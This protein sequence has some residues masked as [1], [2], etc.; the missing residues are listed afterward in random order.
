MHIFSHLRTDCWLHSKTSH[1]SHVSLLRSGPTKRISRSLIANLSP[2]I[3]CC[4]QHV[5][6][7]LD[8]H[9][10]YRVAASQLISGAPGTFLN[11]MLSQKLCLDILSTKPGPW[12]GFYKMTTKTKTIFSFKNNGFQRRLGPSSGAHLVDK[13]L[14]P[15]HPEMIYDIDFK[16][17]M[18][19]KN[20]NAPRPH[21]EG[22]KKH[23]KD[24]VLI[25]SQT[26]KTRII[27]KSWCC[28]PIPFFNPGAV[29]S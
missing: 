25:P 15:E 11:K 21:I 7:H 13:P 23:Q 12:I 14:G 22:N 6:K 4:E 19:K 18:L 10:I 29:S 9:A 27:E 3:V 5:F 1:V 24:A 26:I 28:G 20:Q 17:K 2:S 16:T 8:P